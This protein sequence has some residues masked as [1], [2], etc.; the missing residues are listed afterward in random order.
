MS[1][2]L[3]RPQPVWI[4]VSS[5][6]SRFLRFSGDHATR[7]SVLHC[8]LCFRNESRCH[9]VAG[10]LV[11]LPYNT[12]EERVLFYSLNIGVLLVLGFL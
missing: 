12:M 4:R 7:H 9:L 2:S 5:D 3:G 10:A 11:F 6:L 8:C 1:S